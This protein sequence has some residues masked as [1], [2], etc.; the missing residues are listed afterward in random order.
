[1]PGICVLLA[2][3]SQPHNPKRSHPHRWRWLGSGGPWSDLKYN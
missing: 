3:N 2:H 1:L